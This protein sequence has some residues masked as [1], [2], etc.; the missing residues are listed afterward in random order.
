M[1]LAVNLSLIHVFGVNTPVFDQWWAGLQ[2]AQLTDPSL[3]APD[4]FRQANESRPA[5]PLVVFYLLA[6]LTAWNSKAEML[7]TQALLCAT[8][9]GVW[10]AGVHGLRLPRSW[11]LAAGILS[12]MVLMSPVQDQSF[13]WGIQAITYVPAACLAGCMVAVVRLSHPS[14][15]L[16]A[17]LGLSL[18]ATFSYANGMVLWLLAP[19]VLLDDWRRLAPPG[20]WLWPVTWLAVGGATAWWYFHGF[21]RPAG[22]PGLLEGTTVLQA[23]HAYLVYLGAPLAAGADRVTAATLAG[24]L[25]GVTFVA[26]CVACWTS[27]SAARRGSLPF[28]VFGA[29]GL[30]SGAVIVSGR[31]GF[32]VD[33]LLASRYVAFSSP[34]FAAVIH[35]SAAWLMRAPQSRYWKAAAAGVALVLLLAHV[36]ASSATLPAYRSQRTERLQ[37]KAATWLSLLLPFEQVVPRFTLYLPEPLAR[38]AVTAVNRRGW[39]P[40]GLL[41]DIR[42]ARTEPLVAPGGGSAV[43]I[44]TSGGNHVWSGWCGLPSG[45][46]CDAV[47][48]TNGDSARSRACAIAFPS[49]PV[50]EA[51]GANFTD[52]RVGWQSE[53]TACG[54]AAVT[55]WAVDAEARTLFRIAHQGGRAQDGL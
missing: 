6:T 21:E 15:R 17:C 25:I 42:S 1:P 41:T 27:D 50:G 44:T 33:Y 38:G 45:R 37:A 14:A 5:V 40:S 29:Y 48:L 12:A 43:A 47:L 2:F 3:G 16:A 30:V 34:V 55:A 19:L 13:L 18:V 26:L 28:I 9:A 24:A 46:P 51:A 22:H 11:S 10:H 35:L 52:I 39:L 7:F 8:V 32:G 23:V 4:V 54:D 20:R 31:V 53:A 36:R 49:T